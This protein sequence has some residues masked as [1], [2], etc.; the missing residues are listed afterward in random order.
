MQSSRDSYQRKLFNMAERN[1]Q[2]EGGESARFKGRKGVGH[3]LAEAARVRPPASVGFPFAPLGPIRRRVRGFQQGEGCAI[4]ACVRIPAAAWFFEN[5]ATSVS[6]AP[7]C[8]RPV[9]PATHA[10]APSREP[11]MPEINSLRNP[12]GTSRDKALLC[13][14]LDGDWG[15]VRVLGS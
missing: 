1:R 11:P 8:H 3:Q 5:T 10:P 13:E 14:H 2:T 7:L 6:P 9:P 4:L 15:R 12:P